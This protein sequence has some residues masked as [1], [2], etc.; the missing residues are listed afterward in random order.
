VEVH[1]ENARLN[2]ELLQDQETLKK[3]SECFEQE[4]QEL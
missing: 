2:D 3:N 1:T 4:K